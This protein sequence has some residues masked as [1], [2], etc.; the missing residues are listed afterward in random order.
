MLTMCM[1]ISE[2]VVLNGRMKAILFD[3]QSVYLDVPSLKITTTAVV[4][5]VQVSQ[6]D[7]L[8]YGIRVAPKRS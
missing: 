7:Y 6:A 8:I 2:S 1:A 4:V 3:I 5:Q